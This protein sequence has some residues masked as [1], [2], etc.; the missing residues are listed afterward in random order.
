MSEKLIP[1]VEQTLNYLE[2]CKTSC[3]K[4]KN[5]ETGQI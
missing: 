4:D 5:L 2:S 3:D 1:N